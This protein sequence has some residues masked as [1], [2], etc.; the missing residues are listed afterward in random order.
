MAS[1]ITREARAEAGVRLG[2]RYSAAGR[3]SYEH[4]RL[5]DER[6]TDEEKP[7]IDRLFPQVRLS[8]LSGSLIRDTRDDI[9]DATR[10]RLVIV[11]GADHLIPARHPVLANL[12]I[13]DFVAS[14]ERRP[15]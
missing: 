6:F 3:Y 4:T 9:I 10:G 7:L 12:L 13:R 1:W 14:L 5:F 11:D 2:P 15:A 8:K